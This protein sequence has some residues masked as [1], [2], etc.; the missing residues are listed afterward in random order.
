MRLARRLDDDP[1]QFGGVHRAD[2]DLVALHRLREPG[3]AQGVRIEISAHSQHR[4]KPCERIGGQECGYALRGGRRPAQTGDEFLSIRV[5][6][7]VGEHLFELIDHDD[8]RTGVVRVRDGRVELGQRF[9]PGGEEYRAES[10]AM[11]RGHDTGSQQRR[12]PGA[13]RADH[14]QQAAAF[15]DQFQ[16]PAGDA[17]RELLTAVKPGG[18]LPSETRQSPVRLWIGDR[19]PP[20]G[21]ARPRQGLDPLLDP[22]RG[23]LAAG[24]ENPLERV[25]VGRL[26]QVAAGEVVLHRPSRNLGL[27]GE[28]PDGEPAALPCECEFRSEIPRRRDP[29]RIGS[30]GHARL[31]I[32]HV[33]PQ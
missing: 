6:H 33:A 25:Q 29:G 12:L 14:D 18:V 11:E 17:C 19:S 7:L 3:V 21:M 27:A 15:G 13:G 9:D 31:L 2:D 26:R 10:V 23:V 20:R 32:L 1:A 24:G 4:G 28:L 22:L 30:F 16:R 8:A 5:G